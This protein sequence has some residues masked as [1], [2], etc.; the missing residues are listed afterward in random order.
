MSFSVLFVCIGNVCRSPFGERLLRHRLDELGIGDDYTV[1]SAGVRAL[2][3]RPMHPESART[4]AE[5]GGSA[6]GFVARQLSSEL[7]DGADLVLAATRDIRSRLLE[8]APGSLRRAFTVRE[9][10]S[11]AEAHRAAGE[12][13]SGAR[14]ARPPAP[15]RSSAL[16]KV[17]EDCSR[18]RGILRLDDVDITDPIGRSPQ[19]YDSVA[20]LMDEQVSR[21]AQVL[22]DPL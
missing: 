11:L 22:H 10:V 5:R 21:L 17:V 2:R 13:Q 18:G 6:D 12:G 4:L 15:D 1:T 8:D 16:A 3:G 19:T 9:F 7:A 20:E 14:A